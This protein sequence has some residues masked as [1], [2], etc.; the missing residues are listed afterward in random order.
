[1]PNAT[2]EI[3]V[4]T[5]F[6]ETENK[7]YHLEDF[8]ILKLIGK[9]QH[10]QVYQIRKKDTKSM[11]VMK[12]WAKKTIGNALNGSRQSDDSWYLRPSIPSSTF[13]ADRKFSFQTPTDFYILLDCFSGGE[14][15]WHLLKEGRFTEERT[16]FYVA[17]IVSAL[18][19][20]HNHNIVLRD[21]SPEN[22]LLDATGHIVLCDFG[23]SRT[24]K[25]LDEDNKITSFGSTTEYLAPEI[26][27]DED[28]F[29]KVVDFWSLGVLVFKMSCGWSPFYAEDTQEMY[30]NITFGKVR[31]PRG[32]LSVEGRNFVKGL[33]NRNPKHRLGATDG[34]E[35]LKRHPFF[36]AIEWDALAQKLIAAPFIPPLDSHT[37]TESGDDSLEG[38]AAALA[39]LTT[40]TPFTLGMEVGMEANFKGFTFVDEADLEEHAQWYSFDDNDDISDYDEERATGKEKADIGYLTTH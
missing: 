31:F 38:R 17:E 15:F 24:Y 4:G 33:L 14:L 39:G 23:L 36:A 2:G 13:I 30:K 16:R 18:Q 37:D 1:M 10:S 32:C 12:V 34:A 35:E 26:I 20:V 28:G 5:H 29:T 3:H 9:G 6:Q 11:Y 25:S 19:H 40:S 27:L 22:I 21:I 8:Q 7:S